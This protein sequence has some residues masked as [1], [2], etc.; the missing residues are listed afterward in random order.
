MLRLRGG[1]AG[2]GSHP[3]SKTFTYKDAATKSCISK[4]GVNT[5]IHSSTAKYLSP[6]IVDKSDKVP[7]M[8]IK[9]TEVNRLFRTCKSKA[10]IYWFNGFWPWL[11]DLDQWIHTNWT[12]NC[13]Y[14]LCS[15]GFFYCPVLFSCKLQAHFFMKGCGFGEGLDFLLPHGF[16]DSICPRWL[17]Q[18]CQYGFGFQI[19]WSCIRAK[20]NAPYS[21]ESSR[22][23]FTKISIWSVQ[24]AI[25]E[26]TT[27]F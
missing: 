4:E 27:Q 9:N 11:E 26:D 16:H 18:K 2:S 20:Q 15:K 22:A 8:E 23:F 6:F 24:I 13:E 19:F 25:L 12:T 3:A 1:I 14:Y 7:K 21:S 5:S 17:F 10:I